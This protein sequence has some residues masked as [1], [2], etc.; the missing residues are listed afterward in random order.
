MASVQRTPPK[1]S[2]AQTSSLSQTQTQSEPDV[3][4]ASSGNEYV[5]TARNKRYRKANSPQ[6]PDSEYYELDYDISSKLAEHTALMTKLL[7]DIGE[8]KAQ[9]NLLQETN[10]KIRKTNE[11]IVLSMTFFNKQFEDL[12]KEVE[13]LRKERHEQQGYIENLEK[14][15]L[16]LQQ[17]SRSSGIEI[18]NIPLGPTETCTS[19]KK[20]V[21]KIS[22]VLGVPIPESGIRDIYRLP[23]KSTTN[24]STPR[25]IIAEFTTVQA[26]Q[27]LISAARLFNKNKGKEEKINTAIIGLPG[28]NVQNSPAQSLAI[29]D[30]DEAEIET[31]ILQLRNDCAVDALKKAIIHPIYKS[32]DR[33]CVNNYRPISVLP[34]LSKILEKILNKSLRSFLEKHRLISNNQFGFRPGVSTEDAVLELTQL[35][36]ENL[37][38]KNK[39]LGIFLD[40]SKAFD[41]VS[42]PI[43]TSKLELL[44][45]RGT[46]LKIFKDYLRNRT[47]CVKIETSLSN[48]ELVTYGVPQGSILGPTLFLIYIPYKGTVLKLQSPYSSSA[49]CAQVNS[50]KAPYLA[51]IRP[52][53]ANKS[54]PTYSA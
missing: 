37:D 34:A 22:E 25:P 51:K 20:T 54:S 39:C 6:G 52:N 36:A 2:K 53:Q 46:P 15:L 7:S 9:N 35:V 16:D 33:N 12:K 11:E 32:G 43:L 44:G 4:T 24:S 41:T 50:K 8:V 18:R 29:L 26:K 1:T 42:V 10:T 27:S 3:N 13:D 17:R 21:C 45:V 47:Q 49:L 23:G 48:E 30:V 14:K 31:L 40:L 38:K 19:L 28:Y 5:N